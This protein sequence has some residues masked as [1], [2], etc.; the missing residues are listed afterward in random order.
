M[1]GRM[2]MDRHLG[3]ATRTPIKLAA[4]AAIAAAGFS[5]NALAAWSNTATTGTTNDQAHDYTNSANWAAPSIDDTLSSNFQPLAATTLYF[6]TDRTTANSVGV[7]F[8]S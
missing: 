7:S 3:I 4:L 1:I 8:T 5:S 6:S 2:Q